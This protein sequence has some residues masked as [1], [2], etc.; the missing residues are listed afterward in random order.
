[1]SWLADLAGKA[2]DLLNRVDQGA[3]SALSKKDTASSAVYDN[4]KNLDSVNEYSEL[5]QHTGELKYQTSS[6]A[7][8]ISSAAD[9][10]K[11][12]KATIL[13]GTA[14]IKPAR[15]TSSEVP[16]VETASI[17]RASS[18]F[19]RRKK[20][21]PDDDLLFDFLNSSEKEPNGRM[22]SKKEKSKAT[23]LQNRS[24]TSSIS[25]VSTS[26]QSAKTTED[27]AIRSQG[28]GS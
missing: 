21:E 26:T 6:K 7:A 14:N 28:N 8:Y 2:E 5:H 23:A 25:S 15:R 27:S 22:D 17:P 24:R 1:M 12:Q 3:A 9:N 16:S 4:K 19:V 13:A 18:H 10:I 11:H 20:S